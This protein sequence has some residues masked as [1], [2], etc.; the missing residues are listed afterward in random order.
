MPENLSWDLIT[1]ITLP[2]GVVATLIGSVA[3]LAPRFMSEKFGI[4]VE[5]QATSY[6]VALGVRDVFIRVLFLILFQSSLWTEAGWLSLALAGVAIS[7]FAVVWKSGE[8]LTSATH[9][10]GA[11]FLIPYGLAMLTLL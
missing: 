7:D 5:G 9:L 8:K 4:A 1:Y 10:L 3:M 2:I 6:V 11:V